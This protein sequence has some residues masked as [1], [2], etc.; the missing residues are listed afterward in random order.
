MI[1]KTNIEHYVVIKKKTHTTYLLIFRRPDFFKVIRNLLKTRY[2][3][4]NYFGKTQNCFP[5]RLLK[6]L[7]RFIYNFLLSRPIILE[8]FILL[9]ERDQQL[10]SQQCTLD[11]KSTLLLKLFF[12]KKINTFQ[13]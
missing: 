9:A 1:L 5:G 10:I 4:V 8:N 12:F 2:N 7:K 3:T 13:Y 6:R 11:S